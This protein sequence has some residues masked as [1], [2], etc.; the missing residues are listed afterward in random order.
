MPMMCPCSSTVS[1]TPSSSAS[2]SFGPESSRVSI[3]SSRARCWDINPSA[4]H[5]I[6]LMATWCG[7]KV[8]EPFVN[9]RS[10]SL[11]KSPPAK[12]LWE[13]WLRSAALC[14][15][16]GSALCASE[17]MPW[18]RRAIIIVR[19]ELARVF[20]NLYTSRLDS[21]ASAAY[22]MSSFIIIYSYWNRVQLT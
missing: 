18:A 4:E 5:G 15:S 1:S 12:L 14:W 16:D 20:G 19:T 17:E 8:H 22:N 21:F 2:S 13:G 6:L 7:V 9:I 11:W 3:S 10:W